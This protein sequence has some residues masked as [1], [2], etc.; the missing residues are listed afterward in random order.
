MRLQVPLKIQNQTIPYSSS[1]QDFGLNLDSKLILKK[2]LYI[3]FFFGAVGMLYPHFKSNTLSEQIK[4]TLYVTLI[5]SMLTYGCLGAFLQ[6][7]TKRKF[8]YFKIK[9]K[10]LYFRREGTEESLSFTRQ[11]CPILPNS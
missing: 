7:T 1:V 8:R 9:V 11:L 5:R 2:Q 4:V 6:V 10:K 3:R